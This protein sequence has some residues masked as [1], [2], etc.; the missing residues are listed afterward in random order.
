MPFAAWHQITII[1]ARQPMRRSLR[2]AEKAEIVKLS[3]ALRDVRHRF[4]NLSNDSI[5][6]PN[7][8]ISLHLLRLTYRF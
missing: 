8:G 2:G 4:Q 6:N 5:K 3:L 7:D 1:V